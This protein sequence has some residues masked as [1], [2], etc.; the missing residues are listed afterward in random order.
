MTYNQCE[1]SYDN[2]ITFVQGY[3]GVDALWGEEQNSSYTLE[4]F[5]T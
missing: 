1:V 5:L 2:L 3:G 4:A